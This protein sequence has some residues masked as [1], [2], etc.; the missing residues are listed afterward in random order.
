MD[1]DFPQLGSKASKRKPNKNAVAPTPQLQAAKPPAAYVPRPQ[2]QPAPV[3]KQKPA[4]AQKQAIA[5]PGNYPK[6]CDIGANLGDKVFAK[7]YDEILLRS[8]QRGLDSIVITGT[9]MPSIRE[10]IA[11]ATKYNNTHG[12]ALYTTAGVHPHNARMVTANTIDEIRAIVKANPG[13]VRAIGECGL[14]YNRN[15]SDHPSQRNAFERQI[16][17]AVELG[18]PLFLHERDAHQDFVEITN[19]FIKAGTMPKAVV[20]CFTGSKAEADVYLRMGFY[21]G[22]TGV[23]TQRDRGD[24]LRKILS[25]KSIPLNRLMIET[26]CPYMAPHGMAPQDDPRVHFKTDRTR[27]DPS[28]LF[29][30]LSTVAQCYGISEQQA[31]DATL[32]TSREFFGLPSQ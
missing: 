18:M 4:V 10:A 16:E 25:S 1:E 5:Q 31:A 30:T 12:I 2:Q 3:L 28:T 19:K 13:M 15:F 24:T 22:F 29:Y 7:D 26:D 21:F 17:L 32:S 27:N 9:S 11:T 14:D 6:I 23:V 8:A 20:H